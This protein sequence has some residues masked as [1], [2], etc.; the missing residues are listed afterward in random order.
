LSTSEP[1]LNSRDGG[2][3][4]FVRWL[5]DLGLRD[6]VRRYSISKLIEWKWL[7]P[8]HSI[9]L[10]DQ[11]FTSW[12]D[13]PYRCDESHVTANNVNHLL[14]DSEWFI[15]KQEEPH[16]FLH[17]FCRPDDEAGRVLRASPG[18]VER[19]D[20]S[21]LHG[22][23]RKIVPYAH[24]FYH[25]QGY[26]LVDV[27][28]FADCNVSLL[29]TPH[30]EEEAAGILKVAERMKRI[31]A[32]D[33]LR[34]P[35]RW[36]GHSE[37][38]T[39]LSHYRA[40][41]NAL[42]RFEPEELE[43]RRRG[44]RLLA[45]H[46]GITEEKLE[47]AIRDRF[48]VLA[49]QWHWGDDPA[50]K[51]TIPAW[52]ELQKDILLAVEWLCSFSGQTL[53][54][55]LD[56]WRH[57]HWGEGSFRE[58]RKVLPLES[59]S[60]RDDF[61]KLAPM[62]LK[63]Y[64]DAVP[65]NQALTEESL[66]ERVDRLRTTN[67][68]FGSLLRAFRQ[69]HEALTFRANDWKKLDLRE[70]RPVDYYLLLAIRVEAVLRYSLQ[71]SGA[72]SSMADSELSLKGYILRQAK[73]LELSDQAL[74]HF[75]RAERR[76]TNLRA[77]PPSPIAEVMSLTSD[78]DAKEHYLVQAFLCSVLARNYF[79]HHYYLDGELL[80]SKESQFLL[81]GILVTALCLP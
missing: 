37:P 49:Q 69:L 8:Q 18:A 11:F 32:T 16:W 17:P 64:N 1:L 9:R 54:F 78:L 53:D 38:M 81:G 70:R 26:A 19:A 50:S 10:P 36:G 60:A 77:A 29:N 43:M 27:I 5:E 80:R 25:W 30:I 34:L 7:V 13:Y 58:L 63:P 56:K 46:L 24:F 59:F 52:P 74:D 21:L 76:Y 73:K 57:K 20:D 22:N 79:A 71:E 48:L 33:I 55:Y 23:G 47:T 51:W 75:Q 40:L 45:S 72:L 28:R 31:D 62:Y 67:Y 12:T 39:W 61:V 66:K 6:F 68:P 42:S 35:N 4:P 3:G 65:A 14:W 44:A 15:D 2:K 41:R